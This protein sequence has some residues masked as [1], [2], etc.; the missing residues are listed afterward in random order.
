LIVGRQVIDKSADYARL[1]NLFV[2]VIGTGLVLGVAKFL[3]AKN[4]GSLATKEKAATLTSPQPPTKTYRSGIEPKGTFIPKLTRSE[5]NS[6]PLADMN[7][8]GDYLFIGS[9]AEAEYREY[10]HIYGGK[11]VRSERQ[12]IAARWGLTPNGNIVKRIDI[13]SPFM[14]GRMNG[15]LVGWAFN[16]LR[17]FRRFTDDGSIFYV[18]STQRKRILTSKLV[19]E[20]TGSPLQVYYTSSYPLNILEIDPTETIWVKES[21]DPKSSNNDRLLKI[22]AH[23]VEK[24]DFPSGYS[25]VDRVAVTGPTLVATFGS[26]SGIEPIRSFIRT[27]SEWKE[28]PVPKGFVFSYAQKIFG[29]GMIL[30]FVT[31]ANRENMKQ[32]V[33]KGDSVAVLNDQPSWPKLGQFSFVTRVTRRGDIYV[34]SVLNT[35]NGASENYLLN[36]G[37]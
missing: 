33:W 14:A 7:D 17:F 28:L 13:G 6:L 32:V 26:Q 24:I 12:P 20:K 18:T 4:L 30:G 16:D 9:P 27:K 23:R 10:V 37:L 8:R 5:Y 19:K 15:G 31:D 29:D 25:S 2:A 3:V 36:V 34:R 22:S 35:E 21:V 1:R 11:S